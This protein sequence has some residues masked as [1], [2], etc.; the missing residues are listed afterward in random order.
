[1]YGRVED[2]L[3]SLSKL[4][5]YGGWDYQTL[6]NLQKEQHYTNRII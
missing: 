4:Q 6:G 3:T 2:L 1:M 5:V